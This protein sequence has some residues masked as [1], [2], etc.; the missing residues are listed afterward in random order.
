MT[1]HYTAI[2]FPGGWKKAR[3][4]H[5]CRQTLCQRPQGRGSASILAA[6]QGYVMQRK[7]SVVKK[8]LIIFYAK[9]S[10]PASVSFLKR[11]A[12]VKANLRSIVCFFGGLM[13]NGLPHLKRM[14]SR[15]SL[16][17]DTKE[18][19]AQLFVTLPHS[20]LSPSSA[21]RSMSIA[22]SSS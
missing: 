10:A 6:L 13:G 21:A 20:F 22:A 18:S 1:S 16:L 4:E 14:L 11:K 9:A 2:L 5:I 7:V 8:S 17:Y 12:T 3:G 15:Q 19:I